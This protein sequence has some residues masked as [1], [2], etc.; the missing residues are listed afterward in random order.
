M[1]K[2]YTPPTLTFIGHLDDL[3][4]PP[5]VLAKKQLIAK[6]AGLDLDKTASV[7]AARPQAE[8]VPGRDPVLK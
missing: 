7:D 4:C 6:L 1:K 3:D 8:Q 2:P 5:D